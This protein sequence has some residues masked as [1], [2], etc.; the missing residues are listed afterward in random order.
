MLI[1]DARERPGDVP[2]VHPSLGLGAAGY[3]SKRFLTGRQRPYPPPAIEIHCPVAGDP[4]EPGREARPTGVEGSRRPPDTHERILDQL[5]GQRG[6][7]QHPDSRSVYRPRV[8][9]VELRE[10]PFVPS[11]YAAYQLLVLHNPHYRSKHLPPGSPMLAS[12]ATLRPPPHQPQNYPTTSTGSPL[13]GP[14][15]KHMI[16]PSTASWPFTLRYVR[17]DAARR[18]VWGNVRHLSMVARTFERVTR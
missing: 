7:P 16:V 5:L 13:P 1:G 15:P 9:V 10:R 3:V 8:T 6:V 2:T 14:H 17:K 12:Q 11:S 18:F 4:V